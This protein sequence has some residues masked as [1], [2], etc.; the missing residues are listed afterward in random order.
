MI[1]KDVAK[2]FR[3]AMPL[4]VV[5]VLTTAGTALGQTAPWKRGGRRRTVSIDSSPQQAAIYIEKKSYGIACYTPC[6]VRLP[7]RKTFAVILEKPGFKTYQGQV[8]VSRHRRARRYRFVL[9]RKIDPGVIDVRSGTTGSATGARIVVDGV[10]LG[11]VPS[12]VKVQPGRHAVDVQKPGFKQWRQW[13]VL[14]ERQVYTVA[15]TLV[16]TTKPTGSVLVTSDP[17]GADV[18]VDGKRV[19]TTPCVVGQ[20]KPGAHTVEV[21]KAGQPVWKQIVE[22]KSGQLVKVVAHLAPKA[23]APQANAGSVRVLSNV[24]KADVYVDGEFKG[25]VPVTVADLIPGD[26]LVEVKAKG[27]QNKE[28]PIKV[29]AR[30]QSLVK[31]DLELR[32]E[33]RPVGTLRIQ[34]EM[35]DAVVF[36]DGASIGK[37]P[38]ERKGVSIGSHIV[39]VRKSGYQDFKQTVMVRKGAVQVI[40]AKLL[41]VGTIKVVTP[42]AGAAVYIDSVKVGIT[43]L[44]HHEIEAGEYTM[45]VRMPGGKY[46][47]YR[48]TFKIAGGQSLNFPVE[49][50]PKRTGPSPEQV[51]AVKRGLSSMGARTVPPKSF[52]TDIAVGFPY[53]VSASLTVGAWRHGMFGIDAG[54]SFR[55]L[56]LYMNEF[57]VHARGQLFQRGPFS[58]GLFTELGAGVGLDR[59]NSFFWNIGP[60]MSLSFKNLVTASLGFWFDVYSDRV[61]RTKPADSAAGETEPDICA[62]TEHWPTNPDGVGH[63]DAS[64][65][66]RRNAPYEVVS[67]PKN[68]GQTKRVYLQ[69]K[70]FEKH[71]IRDRFNGWKFLISFMVETAITRYLNVFLRVDFVPAQNAQQRALFMEYYTASSYKYRGDVARPRVDTKGVLTEVDW[72]VYG[73]AGVSFKF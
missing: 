71:S 5:L 4:V 37:A 57:S 10:A 30:Q 55:S 18:F 49:L 58:L 23:A 62:I 17:A 67:D 28:L 70:T 16:A 1:G 69:P 33:E 29:V 6:R 41:A 68:P 2:R 20:L 22:A 26:H 73:Q 54:I 59:R 19:D 72:G 56:F 60:V 36:L 13:I 38:V 64:L 42:K 24:A 21:R 51:D 61:C 50:R 7:Y 32:P 39:M 47:P 52:T 12:R 14:S 35:P 43:P 11:T 53:I 40:T 27:Y 48:K 31:L 25:Q 8:T 3:S 46:E 15:V 63:R 44:E 34:S 65:N 9:Q 66:G 45:E